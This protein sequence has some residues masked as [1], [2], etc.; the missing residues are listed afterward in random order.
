MESAEIKTKSLKVMRDHP[1]CVFATVDT[2][3]MPHQR[4]M[5]TLQIEDDGTIYFSTARGSRKLDQLAGNKSL[6][7]LY[8]SYKGDMMDWECAAL[9]GT[10]V[11][12]DDK[13]L[14]ERFWVDEF[15]RYYPGGVDDP[16]YIIIVFRAQEVRYSYGGSMQEFAASF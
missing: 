6:S 12:T 10:A 3:G 9:T 4:M 15:T 14:R 16:A 11:V 13:A 5:Q 7:L 8:T 2:A 1:G